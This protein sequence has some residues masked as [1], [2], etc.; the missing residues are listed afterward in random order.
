MFDLEKNYS[1]NARRMKK[2]A[3]RELLKLTGNDEIISFAGGLPA[4]DTFPTE[5]VADITK[6]VMARE[7]AKALQYG[8]T[9]GYKSFVEELIKWEK[10]M[11]GIDIEPKNIL[12]TTASQ[13]ALDLVGKLFIDPSDPVL[14]ERPTYLGGL[15][16]FNQYG[17]KFIGIK[18]DDDDTGISIDFLEEKL[19]NLKA[20]EEHYKFVYVVPDFQNPTGITISHDKRI[21]LIELSEKY[22]FLLIE[23][24]PYRELRYE[25]DDV[26]PLMKM[27]QSGNVL[28]LHTMSKIFAPGLRLGWVIGNEKLIDKLITAKQAVD[29][30]T[31][32][33]TQAITAEFMRRGDLL[34]NV[35]KIRIEYRKKRDIMLKALEDHMPKHPKIKWTKPE[36]G[37]FLWVT[38][39]EEINTETMFPEAIK[40]NVA[41]IIGSAFDC[42][43][44]LKNTM[45]LNFSFPKEDTIEEG[46]I[47]LSNLIKKKLV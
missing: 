42:Y 31:P 2:S 9:E 27:D 23:D 38:F 15:S 17:A 5:E 6:T 33:F 30:C 4:P 25:G 29:L 40:E 32:S 39:P 43:G 13:Q 24:T 28:A 3:I 11:T 1:I 36:G 47:R 46:I 26:T 45:R 12:V 16:A 18:M 10:E 14:V 8:A 34:K 19:K 21:R 22:N 7:G 37:L 44:Q 35:K 20:Q 41:Y